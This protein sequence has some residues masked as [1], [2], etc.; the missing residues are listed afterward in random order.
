MN[1]H[2]SFRF[3]R[4]VCY[5]FEEGFAE[6]H[7]GFERQH[8]VVREAYGGVG[9][10]CMVRERGDRELVEVDVGGRERVPT[11]DA[12]L[13]LAGVSGGADEVDG[14]VVGGDEAGEVDELV[15]MALCYE[16]H[17]HYT[18]F[19]ILIHLV[20]FVWSGFGVRLEYLWEHYSAEM[21]D[22]IVRGS[23]MIQRLLDL[24]KTTIFQD[25]EK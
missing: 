12:K 3:G 20:L 11:V 19:L 2:D 17:H 5:E 1:D 6:V 9:V 16:R 21:D 14:E 10:G 4:E 22:S 15:E 23:Q 24:P 25:K 7:D 13:G 8:E 18:C